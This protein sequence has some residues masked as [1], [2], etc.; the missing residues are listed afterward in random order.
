MNCNYTII[1]KIIF[2]FFNQLYNPHKNLTIKMRNR[3]V[4]CIYL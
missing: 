2:L 3:T 4:S 1:V